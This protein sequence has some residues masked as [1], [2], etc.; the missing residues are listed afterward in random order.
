MPQMPMPN[1]SKALPALR[2]A[3]G[4]TVPLSLRQRWALKQ[5]QASVSFSAMLH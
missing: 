3:H 5:Q 2:P 1:D 4:M